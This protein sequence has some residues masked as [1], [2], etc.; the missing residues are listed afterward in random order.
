MGCRHSNKV[1]EVG[2][3]MS[4]PLETLETKSSKSGIVWMILDDLGWYEGHPNP[5]RYKIRVRQCGMDSQTSRM[6]D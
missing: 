5:F 4:F 2:P 6:C 1:R 3:E